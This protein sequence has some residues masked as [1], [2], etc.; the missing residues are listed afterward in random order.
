MFLAVEFLIHREI[1]DAEICAEVEHAQAGLHERSG[2]FRSDAV[3][4]CEED[5][6]RAG[7]EDRLGGGINELQCR[8]ARACETRIDGCERLPRELTRSDRGDLRVRMSREDADE[9]LA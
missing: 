3:W 2:V 4:Q 6:A 9:F 8:V 5:D 1:L 7:G